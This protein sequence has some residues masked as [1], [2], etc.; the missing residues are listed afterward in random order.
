[1]KRKITVYQ[2]CCVAFAAVL[3]LAGGQLALML[4]LPIYLDSIGTIFT[5]A[6]LG[7]WFGMLPN[8]VSGVIMGITVDIYSLYFAPVGMIVGFM[9]GI[10]F[11]SGG[12]KQTFVSPGR[13]RRWTF[14]AAFAITVPGTVLSALIC[15]GL[16]G[17]ITS[18][19]STVLVQLL[20]RT[21]LGMVGSVFAVQILTDY[22]DRVISLFLVLAL[23]RGLPA[24]W[25][26]IGKGEAYGDSGTTLQ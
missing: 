17:G 18:S 22:L 4:R 8:L 6:L 9:S 23:L 26:R 11:R 21:P 16:F 25:K 20:A 14:A 7:P 5:G 10:V 19:G 13:D 12:K 15:A 1:M 3:N 24:E 2:I